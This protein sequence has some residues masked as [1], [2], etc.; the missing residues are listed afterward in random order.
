MI[1]TDPADYK[2]YVNQVTNYLKI[3]D[4]MIDLPKG[5]NI[6]LVGMMGCGK[7]TIGKKIVKLV[8]HLDTDTAI[9]N[10]H[11]KSIHE[12]FNDEGEDV[13]E[14]WKKTSLEIYHQINTL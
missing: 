6:L 4:K 9:A 14:K 11:G 3:F 1:E 12:I 8:I 13:L 7:T 10:T 5:H 2:E